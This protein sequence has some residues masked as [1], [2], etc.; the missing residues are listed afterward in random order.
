MAATAALLLTVLPPSVLF[1]YSK[2]SPVSQLRELIQLEIHHFGG[3]DSFP[4][5]HVLETM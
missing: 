1:H 3:Q 2:D 4:L 5:N